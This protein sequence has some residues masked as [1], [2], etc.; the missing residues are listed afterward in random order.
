MK[1]IIICGLNGTGKT[2]IAKQYCEKLG[3]QYID[4]YDV[5]NSYFNDDNKVDASNVL[6]E[7]IDN[8]L[9]KRSKDKV[10]I[11][12]N[13][14]ILPVDFINYH[15]NQDYEIIYL[16]FYDIDV[17]VLFEKFSK[18]Y[19]KKNINYDS[20]ELKNKLIYFNE[21]SKKVYNDCKKYNYK[22]F[23]INKDKKL[24]LEEISE[25]IDSLIER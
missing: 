19:E 22:Y 14:L 24:V 1:N 11:D 4:L 6:K 16:G 21:I 12:C 5:I 3:Y 10:I 13:Y 23:D 8:Y 7:E 18:D 17:D 15:S 9:F 25:Y 20:S 2:T